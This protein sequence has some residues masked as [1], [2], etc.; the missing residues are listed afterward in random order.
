MS[1]MQ[2]GI[3]A[4]GLA[5][6]GSDKIVTWLTYAQTSVEDTKA[7]FAQAGMDEGESMEIMNDL[8]EAIKASIGLQESQKENIQAIQAKI[9]QWISGD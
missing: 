4:L 8:D 2:R 6:E 3:E 1:Q 9:S 7:A 5:I